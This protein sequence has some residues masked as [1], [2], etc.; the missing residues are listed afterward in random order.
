M[1]GVIHH[2]A[3]ASGRSPRD[4]KW[5]T[6]MSLGVDSDSESSA[7]KIYVCKFVPPQ[8]KTQKKQC[9]YMQTLFLGWLVFCFWSNYIVFSL[10][11]MIIQY[12]EH[13]KWERVCVRCFLSIS[14]PIL[15]TTL[16]TNGSSLKNW[17]LVQIILNF[18]FNFGP[19]SGDL[20]EFFGA[21]IRVFPNQPVRQLPL[22]SWFI[23]AHPKIWFFFLYQK[24][25]WGVE[26]HSDFYFFNAATWL[27]LSFP[28]EVLEKKTHKA[29]DSASLDAG[30]ILGNWRN[31]QVFGSFFA[32]TK[33]NH[34]VSWWCPTDEKTYVY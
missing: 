21:S 29:K 1:A 25:R 28:V 19:F 27:F 15:P 34:T 4:S 33:L 13:L 32:K 23:F 30:G 6:G 31:R 3:L 24:N 8:E 26:L 20:R 18:P 22:K 17:W 10:C 5:K 9:R 16:K 11:S 2:L 12:H 7:V 14:T